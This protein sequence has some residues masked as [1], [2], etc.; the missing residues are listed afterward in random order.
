MVVVFSKSNVIVQVS[1]QVLNS[2]KVMA[3]INNKLKKIFDILEDSSQRLKLVTSLTLCTGTETG[4]W[5]ENKYCASVLKDELLPAEHFPSV[6]AL[7]E[8]SHVKLPS[9]W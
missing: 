4:S 8:Y 1:S 3:L 5:E 9:K 2:F 7:T 6:Q